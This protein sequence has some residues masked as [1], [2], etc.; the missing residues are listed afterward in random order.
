MLLHTK[1]NL[2]VAEVVKVVGEGAEAIG[3][4]SLV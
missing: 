2:T 3:V 1:D 4:T